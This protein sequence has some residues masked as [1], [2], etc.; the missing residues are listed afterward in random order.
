L[1][2]SQL[3]NIDTKFE[4]TLVSCDTQC[5]WDKAYVLKKFDIKELEKIKIVGRGGTV[6]SDYFSEYEDKI[7]K[8]DF[9]IVITDGHLFEE[10]LNKMKHPGT[11]VFW[12]VVGENFSFKPRFGR[13]FNLDNSRR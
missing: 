6:L 9:H 7:G 5:Y 12:L 2:V 11:D 1:G 8:C 13:V 3:Q 4:G 10:D